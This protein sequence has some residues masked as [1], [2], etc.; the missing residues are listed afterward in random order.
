MND[1]DSLTDAE[2]LALSVI[3]KGSDRHLAGITPKNLIEQGFVTMEPVLT[4][5]G[6]AEI[7]KRRGQSSFWWKAYDHPSPRVAKWKVL[8]ARWLFPEGNSDLTTESIALGA[9]FPDL[10]SAGQIHAAGYMRFCAD[11]IEK[12]RMAD[13]PASNVLRRV[14]GHLETVRAYLLTREQLAKVERAGD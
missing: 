1:D 5:K 2:V 3:E 8:L 10:L 7:D 12:G 13:E 4:A 9:P 6:K 11:E 14:A